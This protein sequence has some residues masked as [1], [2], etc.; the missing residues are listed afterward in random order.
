MSRGFSDEAGRET[1]PGLELSQNDLDGMTMDEIADAVESL[2][3]F[4]ELKLLIDEYDPAKSDW[5]FRKGVLLD[6]LVRLWP[7]PTGK[8]H[9]VMTMEEYVAQPLKGWHMV[10]RDVDGFGGVGVR[11]LGDTQ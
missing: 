2:T 3:D 7:Q 1:M 9:K 11:Y 8:P 6:I 10:C 5:N 4:A